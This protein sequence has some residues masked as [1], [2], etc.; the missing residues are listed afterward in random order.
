MVTRLI[1]S[2][3]ITCILGNSQGFSLREGNLPSK[4]VEKILE[5]KFDKFKIEELQIFR[6][7]NA[8]DAKFFVIGDHGE[9][10]GTKDF[11][12][13][14]E[15][16]SLIDDFSSSDRDFCP[17]V[18]KRISNSLLNSK[19]EII[20]LFSITKFFVE[21]LEDE[22]PSVEVISY[23][24]ITDLFLKP[25]KKEQNIYHVWNLK[26]LKTRDGK[27]LQLKDI[28]EFEINFEV[29]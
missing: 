19:N 26:G 29:K 4:Y 24:Q 21:N 6:S 28:K 1:F 13:F 23:D 8:V 25:L 11:Q 17:L 18:R 2:L 3:F 10:G 9:G 5:K 16:N 14:D 15:L 12:V 20:P 7:F 27:V 22:E